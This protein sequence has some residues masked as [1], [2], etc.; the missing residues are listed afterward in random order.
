MYKNGTDA[1]DEAL[2]EMF[3]MLKLP[4]PHKYCKCYWKTS[5]LPFTHTHTHARTHARTHTHTHTHTSVHTLYCIFSSIIT[6]TLCAGWFLCV[7]VCVCL[8]VSLVWAWWSQW[9][10]ACVPYTFQPLCSVVC[11]SGNFVLIFEL[12]LV[13]HVPSSQSTQ[14][15]LSLRAYPMLY[16]YSERLEAICNILLSE[17]IHKTLLCLRHDL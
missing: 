11:S 8:C 17:P 6:H 5:T 4:P 15:W 13:H 7:C 14:H 12:I 3:S 1:I 2:K 10:A 16:I 9:N